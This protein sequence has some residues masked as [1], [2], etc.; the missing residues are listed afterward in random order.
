MLILHNGHIHA[1]GFEDATAIVIEG[2]EILALGSDRD[3]LNGGF[4]ADTLQDLQGRTVWPGLWDAHVHL[5][6]LAESQSRVD[7]ETDTLGDCLNRVQKAAQALPPGGWVLGHGW[8]QNRWPE[9]FGTAQQLDAVCEGHPVYL[10]A[11]SLHAAWANSKAFQLAG[12]HAKSPDPTG[13]FLQRDGNGSLTGILFEASAM[14]MVESVIPSTS[15]R[16][17]QKGI[18]RLIPQLWAMGLVGVHDFDEA[19]YWRIF[20]D[21]FHLGR[22]PFRFRKNI[23]FE[24]REH[25]AEL[26][27]H[28]DD[29]DPFLQ[30]GAL[31]LFADGAL[32]PQT[33]A[34]L[35]PYE[36]GENRGELLMT[37]SEILE[38]GVCAGQSGL[39]LTVHAIGDRAIRTVLN[40]FEQLREHERQY[41]LIHPLHR[42]EHV[43][44]ISPDD[45]PRLT[46]L[47][48]VASVQPI[49]APSDMQMADR[50][51]GER[52]A[53]SYAYRS[54]L[55]SG[56]E[57][58]CG[59]DAPVESINPFQ[60]LHAAVT[61]RRPDGKPGQDGWHSEQR[62]TLAE[63]LDG[64]TH[65][66]ARISRRG[67]QLGRI[68]PGYAADLIILQEDPFSIERQSLATIQPLATLIAGQSVYE[69]PSLPFSL[70]QS[71]HE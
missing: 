26:G 48:I 58:V 47:G 30:V 11:K 50:L 41:Q 17:L 57:L 59:S 71:H 22:Y 33:G 1:P 14:A 61:R 23:P 2:G 20:Q 69:H 52:S 49:H 37:D 36:G 13:G 51:L 16:D 55:D 32:G 18:E 64:F 63:A 38:A 15:L 45:L 67:H 9:G 31:K 10:T 62:L 7:C 43:Q 53:W 12:L 65:A 27:L 25:F 40:G 24:Q 4:K 29:G 28:T 5:G 21:I 70:R 54:L 60:G 19:A 35:A 66:P 68:A 44:I 3:V 6:Q 39:A 56:A 34:M 46:E 8:N 42:I